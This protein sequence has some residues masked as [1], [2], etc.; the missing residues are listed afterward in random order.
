MSRGESVISLSTPISCKFGGALGG[1]CICC[2]KKIEDIYNKG[3]G[4]YNEVCSIGSGDHVYGC[5]GGVFYEA[6]D[7]MGDYMGILCYR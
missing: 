7:W 1:Y 3:D 6:R 2:L 5:R 4:R